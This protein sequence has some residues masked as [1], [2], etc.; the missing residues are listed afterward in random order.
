MRADHDPRAQGAAAVLQHLR[1]RLAEPPAAP[2]V[3]D[4]AAASGL[5]DAYNFGTL[6]VTSAAV[7]LKLRRD[8]HQ[9]YLLGAAAP[10]RVR[11]GSDVKVRILAQRV[12]GARFTRTVKVHIPRYLEQGTQILTLKG[13]AADAVAGQGDAQDLSST[14]TITLGDQGDVR[15]RRSGPRDLDELAEAFAAWPARTA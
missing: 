14:F 10:T 15:R 6:H 4:F 8:L 12:R 13:T 7:N 9:A 1:R 2:L 3:A 5:L 11:R